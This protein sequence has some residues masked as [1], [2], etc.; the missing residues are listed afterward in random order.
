MLNSIFPTDLV[1]ENLNIFL[2]VKA[3]GEDFAI[4]SQNLLWDAIAG[5]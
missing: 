1:K 3:T 5:Q 4:I 2:G